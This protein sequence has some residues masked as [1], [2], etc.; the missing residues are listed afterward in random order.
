[1]RHAELITA[2]AVLLTLRCP[3]VYGPHQGEQG[4]SDF[5]PLRAGFAMDAAIYQSAE[6]LHNALQQAGVKNVVF[7]DA[8]GW[9]TSGR[10]GGSPSSISPRGCF[11]RSSDQRI[12][13]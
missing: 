1:M 9:P 10:P 2:C 11:S 8:R 12:V 4:Q 3:G 6:N 5:P 7:R 13:P